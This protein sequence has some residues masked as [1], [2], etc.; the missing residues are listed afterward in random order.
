MKVFTALALLGFVAAYDD[1]LP[2][3]SCGLVKPT[4]V[5]Y[6]ETKTQ[7]ATNCFAD[8]QRSITL[9]GYWARGSAIPCQSG[10]T[11]SSLFKFSEPLLFTDACHQTI[12]YR[13]FGNDWQLESE[14]DVVVGPEDGFGC[15][16]ED[17]GVTCETHSGECDPQ[18][19]FMELRVTL[20]CTRGSKK[21]EIL[22]FEHY[23]K[24]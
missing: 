14:E 3:P 6:N 5:I 8:A 2:V 23:I 15:P 18:P 9:V 20:W 7:I 13:A 22:R 17:Q 10:D 4:T 24:W 21:D 16:N 1:A 19:S 12:E 11:T